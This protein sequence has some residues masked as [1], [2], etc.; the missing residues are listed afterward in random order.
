[1]LG[2]FLYDVMNL[3]DALSEHSGPNFILNQIKG[4]KVPQP[5]YFRSTFHESRRCSYGFQEALSF[6]FSC[7]HF[8]HFSSSEDS[9]VLPILDLKTNGE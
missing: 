1:M 8:L 6:T 4:D 7:L 5:N 9:S 3:S 2:G